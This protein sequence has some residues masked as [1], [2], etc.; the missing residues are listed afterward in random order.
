MPAG[1]AP[2]RVRVATMEYAEVLR[3]SLGKRVR[4]V[5]LFGSWARGEARPDSDVDVWVLV[6]SLDETTRYLPFELATEVSLRHDLD[7]APAVM[8]ETEWQ[9]LCD[10]ER[11]IA[12]DIE[13]EGVLL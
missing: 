3:R 12:R 5:R 9:H 8:D 4:A 13:E 1:F 11:R 6:D 2:E 7:L 10:R